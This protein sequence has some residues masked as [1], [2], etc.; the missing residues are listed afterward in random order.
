MPSA[1]STDGGSPFVDHAR[2]GERH[3]PDRP[4][5]RDRRRRGTAPRRR[6]GRRRARGAKCS[7]TR[8]GEIQRSG[9]PRSKLSSDVFCAQP[10]ALAASTRSSGH[11]HAVEHDLVEVRRPSRNGIGLTVTPVDVQVDDELAQPRVTVVVL[12]RAAEHDGVVGDVCVAGPDLRAGELVS[13]VDLRRARRHRSEVAAR[14][15]F[16]HADGERRSHPGRW[17]EG[18]AASASPSRTG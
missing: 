2:D 7:T 1:D 18:S 3:L 15:R 8:Y 6:R 13:A 10:S 5:A 12:A 14:V 11:E 9:P 4:P 17:A 16:A